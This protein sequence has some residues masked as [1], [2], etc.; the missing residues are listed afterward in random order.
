MPTLLMILSVA[1]VFQVLSTPEPTFLEEATR[2][3]LQ[4]VVDHQNGSVH[5]WRLNVGFHADR[6]S[7][8]RHP[9]V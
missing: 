4:V 2:A 3:S 8:S 7:H 6:L 1:V 9:V 5:S